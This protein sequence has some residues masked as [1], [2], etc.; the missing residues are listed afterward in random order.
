MKK[1]LFLVLVAIA[2]KFAWG[3]PL[4]KPTSSYSERGWLE[5]IG[6]YEKARQLAAEHNATVA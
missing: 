1:L 3:Y 2:A 5:G 6:N 4:E